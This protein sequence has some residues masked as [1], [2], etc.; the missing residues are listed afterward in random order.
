MRLDT[1]SRLLGLVAVVGGCLMLQQRGIVYSIH[2]GENVVLP[3]PLY[4]ALLA[5]GLAL[6][7]IPRPTTDILLSL[8]PRQ[9][10]HVV[11]QTLVTRG[12][13]PRD[14]NQ[15]ETTRDLAEELDNFIRTTNR[16]YAITILFLLICFP[17]LILGMLSLNEFAR[18]SDRFV[19]AVQET[20]LDF[21]SS[22]TI[23]QYL[24]DAEPDLR[25]WMVPHSN[26]REIYDILKELYATSVQSAW[27]FDARMGDL[28]QRF[29]HKHVDPSTGLLTMGDLTLYDT[30]LETI[31]ARVT[32]LSL[33]AVLCTREGDNGKHLDPYL[34]SKQLLNSAIQLA[35]GR[36]LRLPMTKN[37]MGRTSAGLL[38]CWKDY[39]SAYS[40]NGNLAQALGQG[41]IPR[42]IDLAR[43]ALDEYQQAA[44]DSTTALSK[45]RY[46]NNRIDLMITLLYAIH[47]EKTL[48][49]NNEAGSA[50]DTAFVESELVPGPSDV[51]DFAA[52]ITK[53]LAKSSEALDGAAEMRKVPEIYFTHAQ[54]FVLAA[55]LA[56]HYGYDKRPCPLDTAAIWCRPSE[57]GQAAVEN[58]RLARLAG[59]SPRLFS[60]AEAATLHLDWLWRQPS[61]KTI[62]E[63][64]A[65]P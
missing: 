2:I 54:L 48:D 58:L 21:A 26:T 27:S 9:A 61:L 15:Q 35:K 46:I 55:K 1:I 10:R 6:V 42:Q 53:S 59:L 64:T 18:E 65:K 3:L 34:Q 51:P 47:I 57:L 52:R 13:E 36:G 4:L 8:L 56:E 60:N 49:P 7:I 40:K 12:L 62:M 23:T 31:R 29:I 32:Y 63:R 38:I 5:L 50:D 45:A 20:S 17:S 16:R 43:R 22:D 37:L 14:E 33:L 11:R 44:D 30:P 19:A 28:Y 41:K 39:L 25:T 24:V